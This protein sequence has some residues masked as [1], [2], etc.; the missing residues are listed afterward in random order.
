MN[1]F[2][3]C[4]SVCMTLITNSS[5]LSKLDPFMSV[6]GILHQW[7]FKACINDPTADL[8]YTRET[9]L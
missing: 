8:I 1:A 7:M 6:D 4:K 2:Q 5:E 9:I 3:A